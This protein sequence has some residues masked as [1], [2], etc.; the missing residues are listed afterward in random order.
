MDWKNILHWLTLR[1]GL[2][3]AVVFSGGEPTLQ[4]G[5]IQA[6]NDVK[7]MGFEIGLHTG[8]CRPETIRE[9]LPAL[10][11]IGLDIK[12]SKYNYDHIT[13]VENSGMKAWESLYIILQSKIAY[14]IR[15]TYHPDLIKEV[16]MLT[17]AAELAHSDVK[18]WVVQ[19]FSAKGCIDYELVANE[20]A[21][22]SNTFLKQLKAA[23]LQNEEKHECNNLH[24]KSG[25][26]QIDVELKTNHRKFLIR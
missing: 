12:S 13:G 18:N 21:T 25:L 3:D 22:P 20:Q 4:N 6:I 17:L 16:D 14:E 24:D 19:L 2:L 23:F 10:D 8:G 11:W 5:L 9:L 15:T 26:Y 1:K 7:N